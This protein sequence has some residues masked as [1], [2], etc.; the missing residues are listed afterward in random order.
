[1]KVA[2]SASGPELSSPVDVRFGRAPWFIIADTETDEWEA[3]ENTQNLQAAQGAGIQ[4][5]ECVVQHGAETVVTGHCGPN[6][7][8][9]LGAAGVKVVVG[10]EGTVAEVLERLK[11][12]ELKP[13]DVADVEGHWA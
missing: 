3:V 4:S 12:G 6:A 7:F 2:V 9:V 5:A 1:M 13:T 8:R 10:V 11:K